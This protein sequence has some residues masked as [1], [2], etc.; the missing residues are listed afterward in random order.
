MIYAGEDVHDAHSDELQDTG[1]LQL[2]LGSARDLH[3]LTLVGG[4]G[5]GGGSILGTSGSESVEGW[6]M[7]P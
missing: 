1:R 6:G 4:D 3:S 5:G 2:A 7:D